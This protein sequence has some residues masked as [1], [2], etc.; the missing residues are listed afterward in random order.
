M[1]EIQRE[2]SQNCVFLYFS[3]ASRVPQPCRKFFRSRESNWEGL[4]AGHQE[5]QGHRGNPLASISRSRSWWDA[6]EELKISMV[7]VLNAKVQNLDVELALLI[8]R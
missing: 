8:P 5:V 3:T 6:K 7:Q 2:T 4:Q 1:R